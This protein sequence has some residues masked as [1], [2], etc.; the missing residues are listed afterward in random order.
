M[1]DGASVAVDSIGPEAVLVVTDP[2]CG[3]RGVL[4]IDST[5]L[6]PAGGGIRMLPDLTVGEVAQLARAMTYKYGILG[7]PRGGNFSFFHMATKASAS[8]I[9]T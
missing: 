2:D 5:A 4:V 6:G 1:N 8:A 9:R 3:M 7:L